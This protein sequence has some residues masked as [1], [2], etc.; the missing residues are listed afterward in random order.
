MLA[1]VRPI[2]APPILAAHSRPSLPSARVIAT[3]TPAALTPLSRPPSPPS[4]PRCF[5][6]RFSL[7]STCPPC[8]PRATLPAPAHITKSVDH[9]KGPRDVAKLLPGFDA[10]R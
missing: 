3:P 5:F 8:I 6:C 9:I 4:S 1:F 7:A 10:F 2:F